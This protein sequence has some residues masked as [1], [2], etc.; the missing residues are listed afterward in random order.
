L[1]APAGGARTTHPRRACGRRLRSSADSLVN[2]QWLFVCSPARQ[3]PAAG[4]V[5]ATQPSLPAAAAAAHSSAADRVICQR[6]RQPSSPSRSA[7]CKTCSPGR[8]SSCCN[9]KFLYST[10]I[11]ISSLEMASPGNRHCANCIGTPVVKHNADWREL[12]NRN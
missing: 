4:W 3:Q 6:H 10:V 11:N 7:P 2:N 9:V 1:L 5:R 8:T 12:C